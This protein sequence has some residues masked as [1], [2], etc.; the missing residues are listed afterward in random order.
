MTARDVVVSS[1]L[2]FAVFFMLFVAFF[3]FSSLFVALQGVEI[4]ADSAGTV[5]NSG[6]MMFNQLDKIA[7]AFFIGMFL[8]II[9]TSWF[10]SGNPLGMI[11]YFLMG[12]I[13][14]LLSM[15]ISNIWEAITEAAPFTATL[16]A[17]PFAN[18]V[19]TNLALY[20]GIFW[21]VGIVVT[22]AK[23]Y[24]FNNNSG[25]DGGGLP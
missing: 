22:F 14:V 25:F 10:V 2:F 23:P 9:G 12:V 24:I 21:F 17:F 19:M 4:V 11:A 1:I 5:I 7:V 6:Q 15:F 18:Y 20:I 13:S 3:V 8:S 16:G